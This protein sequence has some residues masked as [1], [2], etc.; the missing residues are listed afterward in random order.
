MSP[1]DDKA[2]LRKEFRRARRNHHRAL[3]PQGLRQAA[4]ALANTALDGIQFP[5]GAIVA[6]YWPR[7]SEIDPRL[8]M[9]RL[10]ERGHVLALPVVVG[11]GKPL[12]FRA[13]EPGVDLEPGFHDIPVPCDSAA[14]VEPDVM[15]VPMI[16]FDRDLYR[17]GQGG[18]YY[19]RTFARRRP[20]LAVGLAFA[21]QEAPKLPREPGDQPMDVI[22]TEGGLIGKAQGPADPAAPGGVPVGD[23]GV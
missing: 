1:V 13:W 17:L 16:A 3:G 5:D 4:L 9:A 8:L 10:A 19:D 2:R 20:V 22:A 14:I 18:G 6:G 12:I 23:G 11:V 7:V 15:L 21:L